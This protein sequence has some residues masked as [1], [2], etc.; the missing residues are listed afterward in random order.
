MKF[1]TL[2]KGTPVFHGTGAKANFRVFKNVPTWFVLEKED[3]EKWAGWTSTD[4]GPRRLLVCKTKRKLRLI[5]TVDI[6]DYEGMCMELT[7][8]EEPLIGE[9]ARAVRKAGY[10]GWCG[11][12]EIMISKPTDVLLLSA[13]AVED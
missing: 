6:R 12:T 1:T 7:G 11:N 5:D 8:S 3:A 2:R 13:E 10:D 9:I 4:S